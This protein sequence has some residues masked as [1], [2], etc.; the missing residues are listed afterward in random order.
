[1]AHILVVSTEN[2]RLAATMKSL[3]NGGYDVS[4]VSSFQEARQF[5]AGT[6]TDLVIADERLGEFNALHVILTARASNPDLRAIVTTPKHPSPGLEADAK[7]FRIA[8]SPK[9]ARAADWLEH[10][11]LRRLGR[12]GRLADRARRANLSLVASA[13][14]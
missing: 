3:R 12:R 14:S 4:G 9:P 8:C 10:P 13:A 11:E 1:M 6:P 7:S 5:L 2:T